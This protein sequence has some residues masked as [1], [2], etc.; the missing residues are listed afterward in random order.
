MDLYEFQK[1]AIRTE[2]VIDDVIIKKDEF[3]YLIE[4]FAVLGDMLDCYKKK[5]FYK[6]DTKYD[7][8]FLLSLRKLQNLTFNISYAHDQ[9]PELVEHISNKQ[10]RVLH[11][12]LGV[13]TESAEL[14][15]ILH[16]FVE[17]GSLDI[18]NLMEEMADGAGGTNSWYTAVLCDALGIDPYEPMDKVIR[19]L[20][21]RFPN[22]YCDDRAENRNIEAERA[23]LES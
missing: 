9:E 13:C 18:V 21:A 14:A 23:E 4:A 17:D 11:G 10:S 20:K 3:L 7:E 5:I 15:Q 6:K 12:M 1:L 16:K 19:K 22:N 8:T 2:S